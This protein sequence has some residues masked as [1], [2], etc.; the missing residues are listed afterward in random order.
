MENLLKYISITLMLCMTYTSEGQCVADFDYDD[1]S[2]VVSFSD[3]SQHIINDDII[4]YI[5]DFGDNSNASDLASPQHIYGA[6]GA[7]DVTLIITTESGC[8]DT[9][10]QSI[11]ICG[12]NLTYDLQIGCD[13]DN[14]VSLDLLI[15]D[16]FGSAEE[17]NVYIDGDILNSNPL[18]II[19]DTVSLSTELLADGEEH[20]IHI[21]SVNHTNCFLSE[22]IEVTACV[23]PCYVSK[24]KANITNN[25]TINAL[26]T[27]SGYSPQ[28]LNVTT[29]DTIIYKW[30]SDNKSIT[31]KPNNNGQSW[32]SG[33]LNTGDEFKLYSYAPGIFSYSSSN[34]PIGF[35]E[36]SLVSTCPDSAYYDL[37]LTFQNEEQSGTYDVWIDGVPTDLND[38]PYAANGFDTI[39]LVL[40][41]DGNIH[42]YK[43]ID[44]NSPSCNLITTV[45]AP[46]CGVSP[47]CNLFLS[48]AQITPCD[49]DS[50]VDVAFTILSAGGGEN[51]F[52]LYIDEELYESNIAYT[53][54]ETT[55]IRPLFGDGEEHSIQIIDT[56]Q[57]SCIASTTIL[58]EDCTQP[59]IIINAFAGVGS[60]NNF[61]SN[62]LNDS[63]SPKD[64]TISVG[65][66][67]IWQ[68]Q[69][70]TLRSVTAF[71]FLFDSGVKGPGTSY[72]SPILPIG[73]HRYYSE[74]N[75]M[76]GSITVEPN[77]ESGLIPIVYNFNKFGGANTGYN[78][79]V[80]SVKINGDPIPY[81]A[82]GNNSGNSLVAGNGELHQVHIVDAV[83]TSCSALQTF[84]APFC[85]ASTCALF[86]ENPVI[87]DCRD[88]NFFDLTL[89][90]LS[91]NTID[92][93]FVLSINDIISD[94]ITYDTT[95]VTSLYFRLPGDGTPQNI[96]VRDLGEESCEALF[97][98]TAP[99]CDNPCSFDAIEIDYILETIAD[100]CFDGTVQL[101]VSTQA[102]HSFNSDYTISITSEN[103]DIQET[104]DY[105]VDGYISHIFQLPANGELVDITFTNLDD[106]V[107]QKDTTFSIY[108]CNPDPCKISLI[109][110]SYGSCRDGGLMDMTIEI[111]TFRISDSLS[112]LFD[113]EQIFNGS[114]SDFYES[115][116]FEIAYTGEERKLT[117]I[118]KGVDECIT[119][120]FFYTD[121]C[122]TECIIDV[123]YVLSD[124]CI[125]AEDPTYD[126]IIT[127][128]VLNAISDSI[129]LDLVSSNISIT[130]S[131]EELINGITL[132]IDRADNNPTLGVFDLSDDSCRKFLP[133][134][135]PTCILDCNINIES[136]NQEEGDCINGLR[137]VTF[138]ISYAYQDA[139]SIEV[140]IDG[141]ISKTT[142]YPTDSL[143]S[144]ELIG[145]GQTHNVII[146]D[147]NNSECADTLDFIVMPCQFSCSDFLID[148]D[149]DIDTLNKTV[150]YNDLTTGNPDKW[151][152]DF[153]DG[154]MSN[155]DNPFH[156]YTDFGTYTI[157]LTAQNIEEGC[158]QT[159][160]KDI[161]LID[162]DC[163][164]DFTYA[165][166]E[167]TVNFQ[168][169][170]MAAE[171]INNLV[172]TLDGNT[173]I[174]NEMTGS[175]TSIQSESIELCLTIETITNCTS[176]YCETIQLLNPCNISA[177]FDASITFDSIR[178]I[179]NSLGDYTNTTWTFGDGFTFSGNEVEYIYPQDGDYEVCMTVE[180]TNAIDCE[181]TI[182]QMI[183]INSC[184]A[185]ASF[186]VNINQDTLN[187][188]L[189]APLEN[190]EISWDLG[191]GFNANINP[192][193]FVYT[194]EGDYTICATVTDTDLDNCTQTYCEDIS[195]ILTSIEANALHDL[196]VYPNPIKVGE[197][198]SIMNKEK[199]DLTID[200]YTPSG[201]K[202]KA[203]INDLGDR[204]TISTNSLL[205]GK[206]LVQI[207]SSDESI[208]KSIILID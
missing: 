34:T 97:T 78:I 106:I 64:I 2:L 112:I 166:D 131:Y 88:D 29:G 35:M 76:E 87:S 157:C 90:L 179:N 127:G 111:D 155:D 1:S 104:Y 93:Q 40:P 161:E 48:A 181:F 18:T 120:E 95:E 21:E 133:I 17:I 24:L 187:A 43:V 7:Y 51:G 53:G 203:V 177:S 3:K 115:P 182:C 171:D 54:T 49:Q 82:N 208:V 164:A 66:R 33:I 52:D 57:D 139:E 205:A 150:T 11:Y 151:R 197:Y 122:P 178:L 22:S 68:W 32:D 25:I 162:I 12:F 204:Y 79:F 28:V 5:W 98:F 158:I 174:E 170:S 153:G 42:T 180:N 6:S 19:N 184:D 107:C 126:I 202:L 121:F 140:I 83:D 136:V 130:Y 27:E 105:P 117:L 167:L 67:I 100:S 37:L 198:V 135:P 92:S 36:G 124:S 193:Q 47:V 114:Y 132:T 110:I 69:T 147:I 102:V 201:Q 141:N 71:D 58:L 200:I 23:P 91:Y 118:D 149:V 168:S 26:V 125:L 185:N 176:T 146:R 152:W 73:V 85:D 119:D 75:G 156:T 41:G 61:V 103:L 188:N 142:V 195:I 199:L 15:R 123:S 129:L 128:T 8:T 14:K 144:T 159:I 108:K 55:I 113:D 86:I 9:I 143:V 160:C 172:W 45:Q 30:T 173:I 20:L 77:C 134:E 74:Y 13:D 94:T 59:C 50:I 39:E 145:D 60:N 81:S 89:D 169:L 10:T 63:F 62:V 186:S 206:Y 31:S 46:L 4:S 183:S 192:V 190:Y 38:L 189:I 207:S 163:S 165:V 154:I 70:D 137:D 56:A 196:Q 80:D 148:F 109:D 84:S 101:F 99:A 72:T 175:Y 116:S 191:N 138:K 16:I 44:H 194:V 65:D 96:Y